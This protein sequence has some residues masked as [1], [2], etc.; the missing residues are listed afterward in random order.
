M[1]VLPEG[2]GGPGSGEGSGSACATD[3]SV[4]ATAVAPASAAIASD[5]VRRL[6]CSG[7]ASGSCMQTKL[8]CCCRDASVGRS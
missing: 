7:I 3:D 8:P 5:F 2:G 6:R 4:S 1:K